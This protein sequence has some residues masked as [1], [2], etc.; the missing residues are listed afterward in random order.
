MGGLGCRRLLRAGREG[1]KGQGA[2]P[3]GRRQRQGRARALACVAGGNEVVPFGL[4]EGGGGSAAGATHTR[5]LGLALG[6]QSGQLPRKG[7]AGPEAEGVGVEGLGDRGAVEVHNESMEDYDGGGREEADRAGGGH[8][9]CRG[10]ASGR[11]PDGLHKQ[12]NLG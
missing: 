8:R 10:V 12:L 11:G 3:P 1:G 5:E 9:R 2:L 6:G 7:H 4:L